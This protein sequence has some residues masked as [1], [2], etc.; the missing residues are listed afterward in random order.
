MLVTSAVGRENSNVNSSFGSYKT[1][2][3]SQTRLGDIVLE[4]T[5]ITNGEWR[6]CGP[7]LQLY[8]RYSGM[9]FLVR[10]T[11]RRQQNQYT[12]YLSYKQAQY[13]CRT[14]H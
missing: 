2:V 9:T 8:L 14:K 7:V 13:N 4:Y 6:G 11:I 5:T 3:Y 12:L 10:E 1:M